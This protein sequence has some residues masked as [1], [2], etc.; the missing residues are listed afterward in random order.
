MAEIR[1][2]V[3]LRLF[4][5]KKRSLS[6]PSAGDQIPQRGIFGRGVALSP[7]H[8]QVNLYGGRG[9][10]ASRDVPEHQAFGIISEERVAFAKADEREQP[11]RSPNP[12]SQNR[13]RRAADRRIRRAASPRDKD[14]RRQA[15]NPA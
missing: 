14:A 2:T 12:N 5:T 10:A 8:E 3:I 7:S 6:S 13:I 1:R 4:N 15:E 9:Q 11:R